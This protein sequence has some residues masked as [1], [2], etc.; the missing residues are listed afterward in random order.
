ME[1]FRRQKDSATDMQ[2][3]GV[4]SDLGE[5]TLTPTAKEALTGIVAGPTSPGSSNVCRRQA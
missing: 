3:S 2:L 1:W 5:R 4:A